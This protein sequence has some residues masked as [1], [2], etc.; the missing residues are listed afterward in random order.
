MFAIKNI[1]ATKEGKMGNQGIIV[2]K[3][4]LDDFSELE[5]IEKSVWEKIGL[6]VLGSKY[7][8]SWRQVHP[9][10]FLVA[11]ADGKIC[12]YIYL[13]SC[14]FDPYNPVLLGNWSEVCD[15]GYTVNSHNPAGNCLF[16]VSAC[17]IMP[18]AGRKLVES[19]L[20]LTREQNKK[21]S[22]GYCRIPG[23]A[24]FYGQV[25]AENKAG[26]GK[27]EQGLELNLALWYCLKCVT[28]VKGNAASHLKLP[29]LN[30]TMPVIENP[31]P[32][33]SKVVKNADIFY[34]GLIPGFIA[35]PQS[36]DFAAVTVYVSPWD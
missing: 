26:S 1:D 36:R 14:F 8:N 19:S 7:F 35:D 25:M 21:Y 32:T 3:A 31:D 6:L 18:G 12:G 30:L 24:K 15:N 29:T 10:G 11:E 34:Y 4:R 27:I 16:A 22:T 2:R 13:Q 20:A 28:L 9:E 17:S 23:F 5:I 33:L